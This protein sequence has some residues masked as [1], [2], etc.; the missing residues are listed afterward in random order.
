M[1]LDLAW[2]NGKSGRQS[3]R[4]ADAL[5]RSI[6]SEVIY[7]FTHTSKNWQI[8]TRQKYAE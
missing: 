4:Y 8:A 6:I 2:V 7:H 3:W 5:Q 1:D